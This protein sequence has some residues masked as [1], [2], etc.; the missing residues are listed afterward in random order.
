ML[1]V[2]AFVRSMLLLSA[3]VWP[4]SLQTH[5]V[6]P[7]LLSC[8][9]DFAGVVAFR[10]FWVKLAV[11]RAFMIMVGC[12]AQCFCSCPPR[13]CA[14]C[15]HCDFFS[16]FGLICYCAWIV[17]GSSNF[18]EA[19]AV[20][21]E[22]P[23]ILQSAL[24]P[25][26]RTPCHANRHHVMRPS[27]S[28]VGVRQAHQRHLHAKDRVKRK[29]PRPVQILFKTLMHRLASVICHTVTPRPP[30]PNAQKDNVKTEYQA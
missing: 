1:F 25:C 7:V 28:G 6:V 20:S 30:T 2:D 14:C 4:T 17:H 10:N 29:T 19:V 16:A 9:I 15:W 23:C 3:C 12:F 26:D 5:F 13:H 11:G 24:V 21:C 18:D 27:F 8:V 22:I